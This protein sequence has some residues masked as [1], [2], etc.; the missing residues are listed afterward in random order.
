MTANGF[1]FPGALQTRHLS[2]ANP[3]GWRVPREKLL[4]HHPVRAGRRKVNRAAPRPTCC[5]PSDWPGHH[6]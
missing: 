1:V 6:D 3:A 2:E 5:D 4:E